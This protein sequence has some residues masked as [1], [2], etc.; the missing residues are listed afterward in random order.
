MKPFTISA[1]LTG[2]LSNQ[3]WQSL[4]K[5]YELHDVIQIDKSKQPIV[6]S[7]ANAYLT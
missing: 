5:V 7:N 6:K 2:L 4:R 1:P 3:F